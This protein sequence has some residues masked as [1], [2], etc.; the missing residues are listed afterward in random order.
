MKFRWT[1]DGSVH[2]CGF[3]EPVTVMA[4][5]WGGGEAGPHKLKDA[6]YIIRRATYWVA[7]TYGTVNPDSHSQEFDHLDD[8]KRYVEEQAL[9]GVVLNKLTR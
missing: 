8:A 3:V 7:N 1:N 5:T 2:R 6:G 9:I 4:R